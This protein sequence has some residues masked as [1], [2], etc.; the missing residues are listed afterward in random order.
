MFVLQQHA[1]YA[2]LNGFECIVIG[3]LNHGTKVGKYILPLAYNFLVGKVGHGHT[4]EINIEN[5][6]DTET[7]SRNIGTGK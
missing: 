7:E 2:G 1:L 5:I 4:V 6:T 3:R